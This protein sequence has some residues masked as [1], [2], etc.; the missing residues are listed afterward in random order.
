[1]KVMKDRILHKKICGS[2]KT[3]VFFAWDF[4]WLKKFNYGL[5]SIFK[6]KFLH[7]Y[8]HDFLLQSLNRNFWSFRRFIWSKDHQYF[9]MQWTP[10]GTQTSEDA[11]S[12]EIPR[13]PDSDFFSYFCCIYT[14]RCYSNFV[15]NWKPSTC[16]G[17]LFVF[18]SLEICSPR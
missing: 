10:D 2:N 3:M 12:L 1:M 17:L 11:I 5:K 14:A 13:N 15:V 4:C 8:C 18:E 9:T 6:I 7:N 16:G